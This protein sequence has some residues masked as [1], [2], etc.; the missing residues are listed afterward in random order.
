[1]DLTNRKM[2]FSANK[3]N[4]FLIFTSNFARIPRFL[5]PQLGYVLQKK[6]NYSFKYVMQLIFFWKIWGNISRKKFLELDV[7]PLLIRDRHKIKQMKFQNI[8]LQKFV[9]KL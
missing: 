4:I 8:S 7:G 9:I 3:N 2:M 5:L 1:M 6:I